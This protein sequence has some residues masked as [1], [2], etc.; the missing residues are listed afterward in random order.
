[1]T[2]NALAIEEDRATLASDLIASMETD[3]M[4]QYPLGNCPLTSICRCP[5]CDKKVDYRK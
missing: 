2:Y 5:Q 4:G 3:N 1:M